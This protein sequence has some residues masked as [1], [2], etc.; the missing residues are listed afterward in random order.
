MTTETLTRR[1]H[2]HKSVAYRW[3]STRLRGLV[4]GSIG[5]PVSGKWRRVFRDGESDD[6]PLKQTE[7]RSSL[8]EYQRILNRTHTGLRPGQS[9]ATALVARVTV[10]GRFFLATAVVN[11]TAAAVSDRGRKRPT[12]RRFIRILRGERSLLVCDG[13][14]GAAAGKS[15]VPLL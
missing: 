13:M 5:S 1:S 15:P 10:D 12:K 11:Y 14:G 7:S 2:S 8:W 9:C 6:M 3:N 4:F